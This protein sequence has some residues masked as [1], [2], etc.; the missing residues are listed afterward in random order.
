MPES[1]PLVVGRRLRGLREQRGL[2]L[3]VL[4]EMSGLSINAVSLI[5][6]GQTSPTVATLHRLAAA[7]DVRIV[8]FFGPAEAESVVFVPADKRGQ[9]RT[10][11]ALIESLGTGLAG[12]RLEPFR[13]VLQ[14]GAGSGP[15]AHAG[16]EFVLGLLGQV[17]YTV[18]GRAYQLGP[19]DALL[20]DAS[21]L[22]QWRNV[23][24]AEASI[25]LVLEAIPGGGTQLLPHL[26]R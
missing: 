24:G 1:S 14:P 2:T 22:H 18:N 17:E 20:F 7:L 13:V 8:D 3:R 26:E 25:L 11:G 10:E 21:L 9:T 23:S 5:E 15:I 6:R 19:G 12:Q 16:Q 4:A